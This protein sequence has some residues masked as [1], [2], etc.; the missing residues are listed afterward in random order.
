MN[1]V[2]MWAA[3]ALI[4][5]IGLTL[6]SRKVKDKAKK[7]PLLINILLSGFWPAALAISAIACFNALYEKTIDYKD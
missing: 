2:D 4:T 6:Y 5:F 3:G 7:V 1:I